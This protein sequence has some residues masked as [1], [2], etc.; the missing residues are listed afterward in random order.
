L[1]RRSFQLHGALPHEI[2]G[3]WAYQ[4]MTALLIADGV[5]HR[6]DL[7]PFDPIRLPPLDPSML[8]SS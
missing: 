7:T 2:A 4:R 5:A 1:A 6:T 3:D 8:R